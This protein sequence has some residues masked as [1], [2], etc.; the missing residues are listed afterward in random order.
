MS[1]EARVHPLQAAKERLTQ[2]P[3]THFIAGDFRTDSSVKLPVLNP[4]TGELLGEAAQGD[5]ATVRAA[6]HEAKR[7]QPAWARRIPADRSAVLLQ[8]ADIVDANAALFAAVEA[9]NVGKPLDV[10]AEEI[11][12]AADAF[13]FF[14]GACRTAQAPAA[15]EYAEGQ[16]SLVRREPIGVVAGVTPWN[17]PLMMAVWKIAPALAAGNAIVLKPSEMT[18][19]STLLFADLTAKAIPPGILNVVLGTGASVGEA[20][21]RNGSIGMI[22]LTGS[23]ASGKAV[24]RGAA[25]TLK[26]VHLELGGKAPVVVFADADLDEVASTLRTMGLTNAGQECGAA[27]RVLCESTVQAALVSKIRAEFAQVTLGGPSDVEEAELGPMISDE[28][29]QRVSSMVERARDE[30]ATVAAGG[31]AP[32]RPGFFYEPTLVTDIRPGA[33]IVT[34]E[35]FGPVI[36]VEPFEAEAD[37]VELANAVVYG[38]AAS[39]WTCDLGRALRM[40]AALDFGTVWVNSHLVIVAEMPWGGFGLSGYGRDMSTYALNDYSRTKHVS[41][42]FGVTS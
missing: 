12:G 1:Q 23:V 20:L 32:D 22:S 25:E 34:E 26:R 3:L 17:Y 8:L 16:T 9:L 6:V 42:S 7:A 39:V 36:T 18:P 41:F 2:L 19:L 29:R 4:A 13:R 38:L 33:E 15:G 28:Q 24:A 21:T 35:I 14:A 40:T 10:A 30:G 27:T 5:A 37:A 31:A 11:A